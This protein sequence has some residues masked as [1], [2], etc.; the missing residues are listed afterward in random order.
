MK[1]PCKKEGSPLSPENY[2]NL[3]GVNQEIGKHEKRKLHKRAWKKAW[4]IRSFEI[5]KFWIRSAFFWGFIALI[6]GAFV[7]VATG[8]NNQFAI[9]M[10]LDLFL[11]LMGIIFSVAWL[12]VILGS[13][14]W[15]ENWERHIEKL[16]DSIT[17]PLY[18]TIYHNPKKGFYSVTKINTILALVVIIAWVLFFFQYIAV[19][20]DFL[21]AIMALLKNY[22]FI[23]VPIVLTVICIIALVKS[24]HSS[25]DKS[26][27][28]LDCNEYGKFISYK[29][30]VL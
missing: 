5:D 22:F 13:K 4:E 8:K 21:Q 1:M 7:T 20:N 3:F 11:I 2:D 30:T 6:F 10:H 24:G 23:L 12:L 17:G 26:R 15:Q 27:E 29:T 14:R 25:F 19:K 16:E 18:K 9:S 28:K